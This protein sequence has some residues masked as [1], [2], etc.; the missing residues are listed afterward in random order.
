M[1][2]SWMTDSK[3]FKNLESYLESYGDYI[4]RQA[5]LTIKK[6]APK[7]S[8]RLSRSLKYRLGTKKSEY[9]IKFD[10]NKYG[11]FVERGVKGK[12]GKVKGIQY[13]GNRTYIDIRGKRQRTKFKFRHKNPG[14]NMVSALIPWITRNGIAIKKGQTMTGLA[15]AIAYGIIRK[16]LPSISFYTQPIAATRGLFVR[17]LEKSYAADIEKG[18]VANGFRLKLN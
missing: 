13:Q 17:N 9:L 1:A 3:N 12:G 16:G 14:K 10:S 18:I 5:K 4:I 7:S 8:G 11:A 2:R 15:Y 6:E